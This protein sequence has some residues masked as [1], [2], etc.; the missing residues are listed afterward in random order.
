MG[1]F[2]AANICSALIRGS[3]GLIDFS[4]VQS[5]SLPERKSSESKFT[6]VCLRGIVPPPSATGDADDNLCQ[7][8]H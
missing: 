3:D 5:D 8:S 6:N 2:A 7:R 1:H 4:F